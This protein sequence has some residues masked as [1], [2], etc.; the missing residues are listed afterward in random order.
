M[1]SWTRPNR[2]APTHQMNNRIIR[3]SC[4]DTQTKKLGIESF[5]TGLTGVRANYFRGARKIGP[6][7]DWSTAKNVQRPEIRNY[8][9]VSSVHLRD[10]SCSDGEKRFASGRAVP[11]R[12]ARTHAYGL[13]AAQVVMGRKFLR[14]TVLAGKNWGFYCE[15]PAFLLY[16]SLSVTIRFEMNLCLF[17]LIEDGI[18]YKLFVLGII[19]GWTSIAIINSYSNFGWNEV[20]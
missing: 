9:K 11:S 3:C 5:L 19:Y 1:Q 13:R 7:V 20:D 17:G 12:T 10:A 18:Y 6:G 4:F 16:C 8:W 14:E 15:M 2:T